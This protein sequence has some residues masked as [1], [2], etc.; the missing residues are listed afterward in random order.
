MTVLN[1]VKNSS[2]TTDLAV[3]TNVTVS[4]IQ[5]KSVDSHNSRHEDEARTEPSDQSTEKI[6]RVA[7][8]QNSEN[9]GTSLVP[10]QAKNM[11]EISPELAKLSVNSETHPWYTKAA[12]GSRARGQKS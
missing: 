11:T 6:A 7:A 8:G 12:P 2:G 5:T 10:V 1:E 3:L 9:S 4:P